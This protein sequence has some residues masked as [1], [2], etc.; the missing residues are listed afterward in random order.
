MDVPTSWFMKQAEKMPCHIGER[1]IT[2]PLKEAA[3]SLG[4]NEQRGKKWSCHTHPRLA[5][6][7][8]SKSFFHSTT[9]F[10][11]GRKK[12]RQIFNAAQRYNKE[13]IPVNMMT[14]TDQGTELA[15]EFGGVKT[16]LL[17]RI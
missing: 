8:C 6:Q 4:S 12:D 11:V 9:Y 1:E 17:T 16:R 5:G 10:R 14:T 15:C 7:I 13:A 3:P 2:H